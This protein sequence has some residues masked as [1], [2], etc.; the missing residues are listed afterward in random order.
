VPNKAKS[1]NLF[2]KILKKGEY[3]LLD[4]WAKSRNEI[5]ET[6]EA[7]RIFSKY[8]S[9]KEVTDDEKKALKYQTFDLIKIIFIGVP[10]AVIPGFS[11]IMIL[12]VKVGRKYKFNILPSSFITKNKND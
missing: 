3:S 7:E 9:G 1:K 12:I 11:V 6:K 2:Q 4:F 10:L 5:K 8:M